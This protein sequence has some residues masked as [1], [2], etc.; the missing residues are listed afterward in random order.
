MVHF[1]SN[2]MPMES[3][4]EFFNVIYSYY[5]EVAEGK[6]PSELLKE[7]CNRLTD[8]YYEQYMRFRKQY[9]KSIKR[10]STFYIKDLD[11]L[12]TFELIIKYFKEET[13]DN[14]REYSRV[15]LKMTE[16]EL[17]EFEKKREDFYNMF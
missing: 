10:Y 14:Y 4:Q 16:E 17:I 5:S 6:I 15:L 2:S 13:G 12:Y 3:K 9:P 1:S 7:L 11:H 8:Y